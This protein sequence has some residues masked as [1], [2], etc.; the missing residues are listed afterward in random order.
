MTRVRI[1]TLIVAISAMFSCSVAKKISST[2]VAEIN[3]G[4]GGGFTGK[5]MEYKLMANGDLMRNQEF[6]RK[7]DER[8][9]L[10][11]FNEAK[12]LMDYDYQNIHNMSFFI[13][14]RDS[15]GNENRIVWRMMDEDVNQSVTKLYD[16]LKALIK[17]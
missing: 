5:S 8:K 11:L 3:F 1:L 13:R 10:A 16:K 7:V 12:T 15:K 2:G 17:E 14:L 4:S 6:L 9:V